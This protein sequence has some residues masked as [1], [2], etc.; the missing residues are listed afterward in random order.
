MDLLEDNAKGMVMED[1]V[2]MNE[3]IRSWIDGYVDDT[4]LFTNL[5][6][7]EININKLVSMGQ[8]DGQIWEKL[9]NT[10][11]GELELSKCFYYLLS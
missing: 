7:G 1:V 4:S 3:K 5:K 8:R 10:S 6:Y 2:K 11:G 9:L